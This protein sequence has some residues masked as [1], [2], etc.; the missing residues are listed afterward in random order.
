MGDMTLWADPRT[1]KP[2]RIELNMPAMKAHGVLSNFRYD[3]QLDP[4]LFSLDPPPGYFTQTMGVGLPAEQ[5]LIETLRAVAQQRDGMF[6][7][8]LGMNRE[9]IEALEAL[10]G[11]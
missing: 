6:P 9:V 1:A 4:A 2:V 11:A 7:K 5:G 8:K 3:V 10:A